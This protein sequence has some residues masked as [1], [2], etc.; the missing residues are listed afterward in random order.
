MLTVTDLTVVYPTGQPAARGVDLTVAAGEIVALAGETGSGKSTVAKAL[1]G[2]LPAG[3]TVTGSARLDDVELVDRTGRDWYGIRGSRIGI[4]PQGAMTGLNPVRRVGDQLVEIVRLHTGA[5]RPAAIARTVDLLG[6]VRL[7][8][9]TAHAYPHQLS[10]GQRQRVAIALALAGEPRLV[11]AD[12]PTTGLDLV[13]QNHLLDLLVDLRTRSQVGML[14]ISHDLPALRGVADRIAVMYAGTLVESGPATG[15]AH[16]PYTRGLLA[17]TPSLRRDVA[18][19]SIPGTAPA[20]A[21][22]TPGCSFAARCPWTSGTCHTDRPSPVALGP[23]VVTCHQPSADRPLLF[24]TVAVPPAP[25]VPPAQGRQPASPDP[26]AGHGGTRS[27]E[28]D[29]GGPRA[30]SGAPVA[31]LTGVGHVYRSRHRRT[32]ALAG[33]D[34]RLSPGTIL[35]VVGES[36]SG[37]STLGQILLGLLRPTT[38]RVE[39]AGTDLSPLRG[40]RLRAVRHR[41]GFVAQDPYTTLHPAMPVADLVAEPLR[42]AGV[43]ARL[44]PDRVRRALHLAGAPADLLDSRPDQLSGGQRQRVAIARALVGEPVLLI[45]D[46]ATSM[47][48]VSTRAGIA[49]TLRHLADTI[50]LAVLFIT[51]DLGEAVQACDRIVVLHEGVPVQQG[52]PRDVIDRPRPGYP[53]DLVAAAH[54]HLGPDPVG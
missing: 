8:A 33:V 1:L 43:P 49:S 23:A 52:P 14:I 7:P 46:E 31:V 2:L 20:R 16:H 39:V 29:H 54:R 9:A 30:G 25:A 10:G 15:A 53:A 13:T 47:L 4:V 3:S 12:E 22:L 45:A 18:W 11:V 51:H 17:A 42:I 24:P 38:G 48:D 40:R 26:G 37:K 19:T 34:L 35:G 41:L 44:H 28:A 6:R 21:E 32:T 36:G 5:S 50:G 27:P